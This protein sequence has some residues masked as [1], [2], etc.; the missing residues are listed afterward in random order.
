MRGRH[1]WPLLATALLTTAAV[2]DI[3]INFGQWHP[4]MA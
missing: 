1:L 3:S 4:P 2:Q